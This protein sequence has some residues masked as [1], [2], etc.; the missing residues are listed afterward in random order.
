MDVDVGR[1]AI[2]NENNRKAFISTIRVIIII[3][4]KKT[5]MLKYIKKYGEWY[6]KQTKKSAISKNNALNYKYVE[7][8][9]LI[10]DKKYSY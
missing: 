7:D 8:E 1:W 5:C 2:R 4:T 3:Y 9:N 6:E 10:E